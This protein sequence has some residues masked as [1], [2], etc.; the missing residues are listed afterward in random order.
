MRVKYE[1]IL[2]YSSF[3]KLIP[4]RIGCFVRN[5]FLPYNNGEN[6]KVWEYVQID[7][8]S[9]LTIGNNVSINRGS[10]IHAGGEVEIGDDVLVGPGVIIYSQNHIYNAKNI[11]ISEQG[12]ETKK[13]KIYNNV[14]IGANSIILPGVQIE[15]GAVVAAGSVVTKNVMSNTVVGGN[16]AS[17]IKNR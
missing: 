1:L 3:L 9:K 11:K 8:P 7:S 17:L 14:W 4:G 2:W 6:V 5:L 16:P 15:S 10:I 13:V 12:Y